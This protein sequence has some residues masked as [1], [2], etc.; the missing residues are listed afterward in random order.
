MSHVPSH[1]L[2][3]ATVQLHKYPLNATETPAVMKL[4]NS[5]K[6]ISSKWFP[7]YS[8]ELYLRSFPAPLTSTQ[9]LPVLWR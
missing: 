5:A 7:Q 6:E 3:E 1:P 4:S 2:Q 9:T 8:D